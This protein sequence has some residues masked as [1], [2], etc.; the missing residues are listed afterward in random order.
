M[1]RSSSKQP[2]ASRE[3]QAPPAVPASAVSLRL[4][5]KIAFTFILFVSVFAGGVFLLSFSR[6]TITI[7]PKPESIRTEFPIDV[8]RNPDSAEVISGRVF[9]TVVS[10]TQEFS[11]AS[12]SETF[13]NRAHG[14]VTI[15]NTTARSQTL[16]ATTRLLS[17][18]GVLFR[19][20]ESVRVPAGGNVEVEAAADEPGPAGEI[21]PTRFTIPGLPQSLQDKIYAWS[22]L[23]MKEGTRALRVLAEEDITRAS[24]ELQTVLFQQGSALLRER[25][26]LEAAPKREVWSETMLLHATNIPVGTET[27]KFT[28]TA[29]L[30]VV[31]VFV[32]ADRLAALAHARLTEATPAD[33]TFVSEDRESLRVQ[34]E[35]ASGGASEEATL[36]IIQEGKAIL[37]ST[38]PIL[39]KD[40]LAGL[41]KEAARKYLIGFER[42][43][44]VDIALTPFWSRKLPRLPRQIVIR[45]A[46]D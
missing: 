2:R 9:E 7:H 25:A 12:S 24:D 16:V 37:A 21:G 31:G 35:S 18:E 39:A 41:D 23:P 4:Y 29:R 32:D 3:S 30:R 46:D 14:T 44:D 45:I 15:T 19:I 33:A 27:E 40:R 10:A 38:S 22:V 26:A 6:A 20:E 8:A 34:V 36:R 28:L 43:R 42:I 1:P 13:P 5:R 17:P 11:V